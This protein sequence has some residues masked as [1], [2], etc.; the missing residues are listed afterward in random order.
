[1]CTGT[2]LS[3]LMYKSYKDPPG[4]SAQEGAYG[5]EL[6]EGAKVCPGSCLQGTTLG[7][8][9]TLLA[10][11]EADPAPRCQERDGYQ[12]EGAV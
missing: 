6:R 11:L 4:S 12:W 1:M 5:R 3:T 10:A 8:D 9:T 7:L 2:L